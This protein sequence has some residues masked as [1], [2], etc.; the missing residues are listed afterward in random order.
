M[1]SGI[2]ITG[3]LGLLG[4]VPIRVSLLNKTQLMMAHSK[5][6]SGRSIYYPVILVDIPDARGYFAWE[7]GAQDYVCKHFQN[8]YLPDPVS[9]GVTEFDAPLS[10]PRP[11]SPMAIYDCLS[12]YIWLS[13]DPASQDDEDEEEGVASP[14]SLATLRVLLNLLDDMHPDCWDY[15]GTPEEI[16]DEHIENCCNNIKNYL[17]PKRAAYYVLNEL[18]DGYDEKE[19]DPYIADI[20]RLPPP[21]EIPPD[22]ADKFPPVS[23]WGDFYPCK[24]E[25]LLDV[26]WLLVKRIVSAAYEDSTDPGEVEAC[27]QINESREEAM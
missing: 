22:I 11:S 10:P 3:I 19:P 23:E 4:E 14:P 25:L 5:F 20:W 9:P 6:V 8:D 12:C 16:A 17:V 18:L 1:D 27:R 15:E 26:D 13:Q 7:Q 2:E 24:Q 21:E